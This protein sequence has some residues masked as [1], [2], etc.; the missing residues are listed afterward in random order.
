[1]YLNHKQ[2]C[3]IPGTDLIKT[4]RSCLSFGEKK[5]KCSDQ[6]M[7]TVLSFCNVAV[8]LAFN[9][10]SSLFFNT[11]YY[12]NE[13]IFRNVQCGTDEARIKIENSRLLYDGR[14]KHGGADVNQLSLTNCDSHE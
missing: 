4:N 13:K 3:V 5:S 11:L 1:M 12:S 14:I 10:F 6:E 7:S 9:S 2:S 8:S